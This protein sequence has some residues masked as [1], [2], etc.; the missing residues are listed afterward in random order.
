MVFFAALQRGLDNSSVWVVED[1]KFKSKIYPGPPPNFNSSPL[2]SSRAPR[3]KDRQ[4]H[5]QGRFL[6]N[7]GGVKLPLDTKTHEK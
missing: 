5:V 4:S 7:F 1:D 2:K 6:S 3:G